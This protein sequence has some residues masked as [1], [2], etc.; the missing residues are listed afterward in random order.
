MVVTAAGDVIELQMKTYRR[1]VSHVARAKQGGAGGLC[2]AALA[3][4]NPPRG[5]RTE[6]VHEAYA[7]SL[8]QRKGASVHQGR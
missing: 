3:G 5:A 7:A 6:L 2:P 4:S 8:R 1:G